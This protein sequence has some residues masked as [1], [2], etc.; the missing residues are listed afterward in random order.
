MLV[1]LIMVSYVIYFTHKRVVNP[2]E[3]LALASSQVQ[4]GQFNHIPL[5]TKSDDEIG[6]LALV[7]TQMASELKK[8]YSTLEDK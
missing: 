7:F 2:L 6:R 3:K 5:D 8:L 1:I 4:I